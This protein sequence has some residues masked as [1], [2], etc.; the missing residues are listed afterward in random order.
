M[1]CSPL[2]SL[3]KSQVGYLG[4]LRFGA[5]VYLYVCKTAGTGLGGGK[6]EESTWVGTWFLGGNAEDTLVYRREHIPEA[7]GAIFDFIYLPT[8]LV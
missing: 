1:D 4:Y 5:V 6:E 7:I 3:S 2:L 8:V